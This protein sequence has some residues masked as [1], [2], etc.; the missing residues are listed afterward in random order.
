MLTKAADKKAKATHFL[1]RSGQPHW[2]PTK[3]FL[4]IATFH[5]L[6]IATQLPT[7]TLL[8][9]ATFD[10]L[11]IATWLPAGPL[12]SITALD[13]FWI[14]TCVYSGQLLDCHVDADRTVSCTIL[15]PLISCV[16]TRY[17]VACYSNIWP[18]LDCHVSF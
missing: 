17:D 2:V 8:D 15:S 9:I 7:R 1:R 3:S 6:W 16:G 13:P 5:Q 4:V 11:Q 12:L 14:A 10:P 18:V